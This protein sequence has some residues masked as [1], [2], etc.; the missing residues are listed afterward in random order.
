MGWAPD[1]LGNLTGN[2]QAGQDR[3]SIS[4]EEATNSRHIGADSPALWAAQ[5]G[6]GSSL[7]GI[8]W[9]SATDGE[10][11]YVAI[12]NLDGE[13]YPAGKARFVERLDPTTGKILWQTPDPNGAVDIGP[14]TVANGVVYAPSM[15]AATAATHNTFALDGKTGAVL[16][17]YLSGGSLNAGAV[18]VKGVVYW[19]SGYAN[20]PVPGFVGNNKFYAFSVG[21][22]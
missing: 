7:G 11:I 18:I 13:S 1:C 15:G 6:P 10:R 16:W 22:L 4:E 21:G 9:G 19:G 8:E 14:M 12:A 2:K 17:S 20:L 3:P 5:V